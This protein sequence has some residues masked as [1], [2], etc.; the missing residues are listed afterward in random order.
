MKPVQ[1]GHGIALA[2]QHGQPHQ[3]LHAA[4]EG[5]AGFK[6]VFVVEADAGER[7][8][9]RLRKGSIHAWMDSVPLHRR[10]LVA[11]RAR[12][13]GVVGAV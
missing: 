11:G 6:G 13:S 8:Q 9:H 10:Q 1:P 3:R 12:G 5:A 7:A 4:H 2:L